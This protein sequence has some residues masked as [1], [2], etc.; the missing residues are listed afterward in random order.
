[1]EAGRLISDFPQKQWSRLAH[2]VIKRSAPGDLEYKKWSVA[3]QVLMQ[4]STYR[5]QGA[6]WNADCNWITNAVEEHHRRPFKGILHN[7]E[8]D[9]PSAMKFGIELAANPD[10]RCP[11]SFHVPRVAK[12]MVRAVS[13]LL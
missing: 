9:E 2:E 11:A 8:C 12:E 10:W 5:R 7:D 13:P 4:R 1:M 6:L 3:L